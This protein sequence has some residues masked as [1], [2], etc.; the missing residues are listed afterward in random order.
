MERNTTI[1]QPSEETVPGIVPH[2]RGGRDKATKKRGMNTPEEKRK[3]GG[4]NS[5]QVERRWTRTACSS[6]KRQS[7]GTGPS[8]EEAVE[9]EKEE[10]KAGS[11]CMGASPRLYMNWW[12]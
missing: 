6:D 1:K 2:L 11:G 10:D 7:I 8:V 9:E 12:W 4:G 5:S 3:E